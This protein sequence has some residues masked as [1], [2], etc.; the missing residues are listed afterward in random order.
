MKALDKNGACF[1]YISDTFPGLSK[2]KKKMGVSDGPQIKDKNFSQSMAPVERDAWLSFVSVTKNF[3]GNMKAANY[4]HLVMDILEKF[5]SLNDQMIIKIHFL[6]S[7]LDKFS[8][9][10][11]AAS[12]EKGE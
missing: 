7:H 1:Q 10:L 6:F 4:V 8:K 12:D 11:G 9:N 2:E 5:K 3:L